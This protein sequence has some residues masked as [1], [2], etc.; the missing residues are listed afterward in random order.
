MTTRHYDMARENLRLASIAYEVDPYEASYHTNV[1]QVHATLHLAG[2]IAGKVDLTPPSNDPP[3]ASRPPRQ[4]S[5]QG[6]CECGNLI[7]EPDKFDRCYRCKNQLGS[8]MGRSATTCPACGKDKQ[9]GFETCVACK[10]V[11]IIDDKDLPPV[12]Y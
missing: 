5:S 9:R 7:K 11:Q 8:K 12:G 10:D 1:A 3:P 2:V 4:E 6:E